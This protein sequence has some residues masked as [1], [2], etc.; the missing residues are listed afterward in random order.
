M[1]ALLAQ[2]QKRLQNA[3]ELETNIKEL[4][5]GV[6]LTKSPESHQNVLS[7]RAQY[8]EMSPSRAM[9]SLLQLKQTFYN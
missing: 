3:K 4:E 1:T 9:A 7:L 6:Y 8:N 5:R 2:K